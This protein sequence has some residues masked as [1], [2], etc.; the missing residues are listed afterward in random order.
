M[1]Q[2]KVKF[3]GNVTVKVHYLD[4]SLSDL[5]TGNMVQ[6]QDFIKKET[7]QNGSV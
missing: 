7:K 6:R 4:P 2:N 3:N 1:H 5:T